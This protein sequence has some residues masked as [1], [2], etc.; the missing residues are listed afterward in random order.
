MVKVVLAELEWDMASIFE[1]ATSAH[2]SDIPTLGRRL[3]ACT[4]K[5]RMQE[6]PAAARMQKAALTETQLHQQ[7]V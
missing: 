4:C 6:N 3:M 5:R 2:R 7:P 1:H